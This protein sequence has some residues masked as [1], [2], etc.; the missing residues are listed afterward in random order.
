MI[1]KFAMDYW[2]FNIKILIQTQSTKVSEIWFSIRK[3][4]Y[5]NLCYLKKVSLLSKIR[6]EKF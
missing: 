1:V 4:K 3:R 6:Q 5:C 2:L